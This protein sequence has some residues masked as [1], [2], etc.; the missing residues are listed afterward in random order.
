MAWTKKISELTTTT[1]VWASDSLVMVQWWVTKKISSKNFLEN[2]DE[3]NSWL[4]T[5]NWVQTLTNKT[6]NADNNTISNLEVDNFKTW[7]VDTDWAMTSNSDTKIPSQKAV[8]TYSDSLWA[9]TWEIK[10]WVTDTPPTN[11]LISDW[12]AV[13]RTTYADL[14]AVIWTTYW[15][16]DWSTTFNLPNLAW[17]IP[18]WKDWA[19]FTA[20]WDTWWEETHTLATNEIPSHNHSLTQATSSNS[21]SISTFN[22]NWYGDFQYTHTDT[23][24]IWNTWWWASHNNLQPYLVINYIIKT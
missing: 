14:F 4:T 19:T 13:S 2:A 6:V 7:V 17:N 16:W 21:W 22:T 18:V 10:L 8:K 23:T 12:T 5:N 1:N 20:I 24:S 11:W 3:Q 9:I 15:A